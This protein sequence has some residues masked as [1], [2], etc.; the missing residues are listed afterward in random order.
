ML[1]FSSSYLLIEMT[2]LGM[3]LLAVISTIEGGE[4]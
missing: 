4:I 2:I 3:F 1:D